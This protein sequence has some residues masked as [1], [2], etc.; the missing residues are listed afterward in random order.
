MR[1]TLLLL[2]LT[3]GLCL[4]G[5]DGLILTTAHIGEGLVLSDIDEGELVPDAWQAYGFSSGSG[6]EVRVTLPGKAMPYVALTQT[7]ARAESG[8]VTHR[9]RTAAAGV[10]TRGHPFAGSPSVYGLVEAGIGGCEFRSPTL[11]RPRHFALGELGLEL[12]VDF[13]RHAFLGAGLKWSVI[14]YPTETVANS[15]SPRLLIGIRL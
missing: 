13:G 14:G 5:A 8:V 1:I 11:S 12:G 9:F 6:H 10:A 3:P 4:A 15:L 7:R 2:S